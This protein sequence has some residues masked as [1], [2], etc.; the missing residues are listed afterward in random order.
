MTLS[1]YFSEIQR[2]AMLFRNARKEETGVGGHAYPYL[3]RIY[4]HP[5]LR[6]DELCR[7]LHVNKSNVTRAMTHLEEAG[8]IYRTADQKDKRAFNVYLTPKGEETIPKLRKVTKEWNEILRTS[9]NDEQ[10]ED[11]LQ[12]IDVIHSKA[13]DLAERI[14]K[15]E[16]V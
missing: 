6:L 8:M 2:C 12:K 4:H 11:F 13:I 1:R 3:F 14:Q 5:G 16:T 7:A 10:W 9:F 15:E